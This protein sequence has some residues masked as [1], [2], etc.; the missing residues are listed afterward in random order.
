MLL[1][2]LGLLNGK[3]FCTHHTIYEKM[4]EIVPSGVPQKNERFVKTEK[5]YTSGG[6]SAGIDLSFY[7]IEKL[8]GDKIAEKTATYMEYE[9]KNII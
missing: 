9:R 4:K 7:L 5:I 8:L 3:P 6:I 1:G 2:R